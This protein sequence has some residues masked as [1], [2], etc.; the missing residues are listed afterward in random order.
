[1]LGFVDGV[2][3]RS[4]GVGEMYVESEVRRVVM[5][6]MLLLVKGLTVAIFGLSNTS[7]LSVKRLTTTVD[8][9]LV[10]MPRF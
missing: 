10:H 7:M 8:F 6:L 3:E 2:G 9:F 1:M 5:V 4:N